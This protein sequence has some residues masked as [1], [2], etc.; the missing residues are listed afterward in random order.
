MCPKVDETP[1][2]VELEPHWHPFVPQVVSDLGQAPTGVVL[3]YSSAS[4]EGKLLCHLL[5]RDVMFIPLKHDKSLNTVNEIPVLDMLDP[6][7]SKL[8]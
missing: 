6:F 2:K 5:S 1:R 3:E 7:L 8:F 4:S